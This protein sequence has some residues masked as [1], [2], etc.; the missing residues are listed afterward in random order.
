MSGIC[1]LC[2][3]D[4]KLVKS[5]IIPKAFFEPRAGGLTMLFN[6]ED[7]H[8]KRMPSGIYD[9][10]ILCHQC[11]EQFSKL[12]DYA[13]KLLIENSSARRKVRVREFEYEIIESFDYDKLKLFFMSV[14]LRADLSEGFYWQ[15]IR[16]GNRRLTLKKHIS[17]GIAPG[18]DVFPVFLSRMTTSDRYAVWGYPFNRSASRP[19]S[20]F[21]RRPP[22]PVCPWAFQ[23]RG[24]ASSAVGWQ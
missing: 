24:A 12:D 7:L 2:A 1:K 9:S 21:G 10:K 13:F 8:P 6:R 17:K 15:R 3:E 19:P 16:L 14:L 23:A 22:R 18:R 11:E 20:V 4:R 5:H